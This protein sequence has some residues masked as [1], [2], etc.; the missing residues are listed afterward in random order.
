MGYMHGWC[1]IEIFALDWIGF[2]IDDSRCTFY[3]PVRISY[4]SRVWFPYFV[5][6]IQYNGH[7]V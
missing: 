5:D 1:R 2:M 3:I 6:V 4:V 7:C